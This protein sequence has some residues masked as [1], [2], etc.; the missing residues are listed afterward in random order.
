MQA[1]YGPPTPSSGLMCDLSSPSRP[2]STRPDAAAAFSLGA[3]I[4]KRFNALGGW[5]GSS[6]SISSPGGSG[7]SPPDSLSSTLGAASDS[8]DGGQGGSAPNS[9][10]STMVLGPEGAMR[11]HAGTK[12]AVEGSLD[13]VTAYSS[14]RGHHVHAPA[15][16]LGRRVQG[17]A[18][19][20]ESSANVLR[21]PLKAMFVPPREVSAVLLPEAGWGWCACCLCWYLS[22]ADL[23]LSAW[24]A[25]GTLHGSSTGTVSWVDTF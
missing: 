3:T 23:Q 1:S 7:A 21:K 16:L 10:A 11:L 6:S 14:A 2:A 13:S 17:L 8:T 5:V 12:A 20:H 19:M 25:P 15:G 18:E 24:L 22:A 9:L 4:H